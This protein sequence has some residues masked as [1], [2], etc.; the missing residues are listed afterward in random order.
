MLKDTKPLAAHGAAKTEIRGSILTSSK[1]F[2]GESAAES[3]GGALETGG[4]DFGFGFVRSWGVGGVA[5]GCAKGVEGCA[6]DGG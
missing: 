4:F 5:F 3:E 6:G 2:A 1:W